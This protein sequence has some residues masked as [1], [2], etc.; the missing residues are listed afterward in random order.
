[1]T[2]SGSFKLAKDP[3]PTPDKEAKQDAEE[4]SEETP[5][6]AETILQDAQQAQ[7]EESGKIL[8]TSTPELRPA[9]KKT[10]STAAEWEEKV[11]SRSSIRERNPTEKSKVMRVGTD[12]DHAT[13]EQAQNSPEAA[14]WTDARKRERSQLEIYVVFTRVIKDSIRD[15]TK[16]VDTK[17]VYVM[18]RKCD[19][20]IEKFKA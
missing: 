1:M 4:S 20:P 2:S 15:R 13:D 6:A 11:G 12:P 16:I 5:E 19:G 8:P 7:S 3:I 10:E 18:K 9:P 17:W 14:K